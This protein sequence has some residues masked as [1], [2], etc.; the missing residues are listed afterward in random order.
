MDL[1]VWSIFLIVLNLKCWYTEFFLRLKCTFDI[2]LFLYWWSC[3]EQGHHHFVG[4]LLSEMWRNIPRVQL[5]ICRARALSFDLSI[6]T[7][8]GKTP[9]N[10]RDQFQV[11][12]LTKLT[13]MFIYRSLPVCSHTVIPLIQTFSNRK[14][15]CFVLG[16]ISGIGNVSN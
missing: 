2:C 6:R 3:S 13:C 14:L 15:L 5:E 9:D 1:S 4:K 10:K 7:C 11:G 16:S 12:K 8:R